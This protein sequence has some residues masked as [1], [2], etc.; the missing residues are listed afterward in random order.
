MQ[1]NQPQD[2]QSHD[3][4]RIIPVILSGGAGTRLWPVSTEDKPKQFLDLTGPM[5]LFQLTLERGREAS[6]FSKPIIVG[7]DR[8]EALVEEQMS[9]VGAEA[10]AL[11]FEPVARNTAPAIA[12][13]ALACPS[14]Q[15]PMLVMP[16]DHIIKNI[17][18]FHRAVR[19][20][21]SLA[22]ARWL[23]TFGITPTGPETGYGYIQ[24]GDPIMGGENSFAATRFVEKPNQTNA[25]KMLSE[26]NFHWNAGI[27]LFRADAYLAALEEHGP[28]MLAAAKEAMEQAAR[29]GVKI[30]PDEMCFAEAPSDSIDYAV[31]EKAEKVAVTPV[32]PGWSDVGSWD[33]LFE[34]GT[35]DAQDNV[36]TG[37]VV[38]LN[39]S[40]N[41]IHSDDL[42]IFTHSLNDMI[43][44]ASGRTVMI[45]PRGQSQNV[46]QIVTEQTKEE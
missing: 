27:F 8:H 2:S 37:S 38:A 14:P 12:L 7:N 29:D 17:P 3:S 19:Q 32:N 24:Q 39:S 33:S 16:S 41:L 44:V 20:S 10:E 4:Q 45:L 22:K 46:K 36:T 31:M 43:V 21:L 30:R 34:T 15:T 5:S 28:Q 42:D 6:L 18:A 40:R 11:I 13:A 1:E 26:G 25:E 23:V 9:E 35:S